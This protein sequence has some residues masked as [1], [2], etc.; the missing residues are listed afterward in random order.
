MLSWQDSRLISAF[1]MLQALCMGTDWAL[2]VHLQI[3]ELR[4]AFE[5]K[6]SHME[7]QLAGHEGP[8]LLG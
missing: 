6:L 2:T 3:E 4:E 8:F 7:S 5:E 1:K